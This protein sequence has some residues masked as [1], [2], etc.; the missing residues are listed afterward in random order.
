[1]GLR[2]RIKKAEERAY[3]GPAPPCPECG[4]KIIFEEIDEDGNATYP[5]GGPC[6]TCGSR[7][8]SASGRIGRIVVDR[9]KAKDR[10]SYEE[11]GTFTFKLDKPGHQEESEVIGW[12]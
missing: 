6:E 4:G 11:E 10:R 8:S 7:G 3:G 2:R 9:R 12:P 1:M 5:Q